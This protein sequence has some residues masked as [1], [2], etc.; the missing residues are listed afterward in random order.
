[1]KEILII[2]ACVPLFAVNSFCD[3]L[4]SANGTSS[5]HLKY[6][7]LKF[8]IGSIFLLP[9]FFFDIAACGFELG[10]FV[11]GVICGCIIKYSFKCFV[12]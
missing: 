4:A 5:E 2:L 6:N 11:C 12:G 7:E 3:K 1:M 8:G 10:A 9:M